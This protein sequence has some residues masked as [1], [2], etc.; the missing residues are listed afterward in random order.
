MVGVRDPYVFATASVDSPVVYDSNFEPGCFCFTISHSA[1]CAELCCPVP[2]PNNL[3]V[4]GNPAQS[5]AAV[6]S[7]SSAY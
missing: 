3:A 2:A 4:S 1:T 6:V 5:S 7:H